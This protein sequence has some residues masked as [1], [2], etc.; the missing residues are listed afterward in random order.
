MDSRS[1]LRSRPSVPFQGDIADKNKVT[2]RRRKPRQ[3]KNTQGSL[4]LTSLV[5]LASFL[6]TCAIT[7]FAYKHL[8]S[9]KLNKYSKNLRKSDQKQRLDVELPVNSI[10]NFQYQDIDG[11]LISLSKFVG[12]AALVINVASE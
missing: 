4:A 8:V 11:K 10:Y 5:C 9:K 1:M 7:G 12:H 3:S 6:A 2:K